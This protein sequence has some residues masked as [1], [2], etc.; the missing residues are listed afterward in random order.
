MSII[1]LLI[2]Y[3]FFH[4]MRELKNKLISIFMQVATK[5]DKPYTNL[6]TDSILN[7][8]VA[9]LSPIY[10]GIEKNAAPTIISSRV[11]VELVQV[12]SSNATPSTLARELFPFGIQDE[13]SVS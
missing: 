6:P 3:A 1:L 13:S 4:D 10:L 7:A 11:G 5:I 12:V 8:E 2:F 9:T